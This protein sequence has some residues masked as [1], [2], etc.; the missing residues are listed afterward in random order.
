MTFGPRWTPTKNL[1]V[2]PNLRCDWF[3]GIAANPGGLLPFDDGLRN[4]QL[5]FGC[6][7]GFVY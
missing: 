5:I 7:L 4:N 1:F 3:S 6:D 2:R